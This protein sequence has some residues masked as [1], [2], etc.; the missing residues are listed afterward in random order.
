VEPG[1]RRVCHVRLSGLHSILRGRFRGGKWLQFPQLWRKLYPAYNFQPVYNHFQ[2]KIEEML[3]PW[4]GLSCPS[5]GTRFLFPKMILGRSL[6]N[7]SRT[8]VSISG[9]TSSV[10]SVKV[11]YGKKM[12]KGCGNLNRG[13]F[14]KALPETKKA[15]SEGPEAAGH[16]PDSEGPEAADLGQKLLTKVQR[17][18]SEALA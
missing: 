17:P 18:W 2:A 12:I 14:G 10:D 16:P 4:E 8:C 13:S 15:H 3:K 9:Y 1:N 11:V 6:L 5:L 7:P